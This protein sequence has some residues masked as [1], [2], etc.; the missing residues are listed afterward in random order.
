M[1]INKGLILL[2]MAGIALVDI[3]FYWNSHLY[4]RAKEKIIASE[5]K[6]RVLEKANI[7]YTFHDPV[8]YELG[9]AYSDLGISH[10]GDASLRDRYFRKSYEYFYKALRMNP[11]FVFAHFDFAQSLLFMNSLSLP[12]IAPHINYFE[13]YKKAALLTGHN[14][15]IYYEVGK[16][17]FAQWPSLTEEEK[18]FTLMMLTKIMEQKNQ[19][20]LMALLQIWDMNV[21][22][23]GTLGK[24]LPDDSDVFRLYARFLG[25][26]SLSLEERQKKLAH[27][28]F[29]ELQKAKN[30]LSLGER[31]YRFFR[32]KEASS[33]YSTCLS[34]LDKINF[35]QTL[36]G[37]NLIDPQEYIRIRKAGLLGLVKSRLDESGLLKEAKK[38][39]LFYISLETGMKALADL[40]SFL[41]ERGMIEK[42]LGF[43]HKDMEKFAFEVILNFKQNKFRDVIRAGSYMDQNLIVVPEAMKQ[44]YVRVLHVIGD[45]YQKLDYLYESNNYFQ[46]ALDIESGNLEVLTGL[47][48][49]YARLNN[50]EKMKETES[51]IIQILTPGEIVLSDVLISK[52]QEFS[53]SL[54]LDG[55]NARFL[56]SWK[57]DKR[58][59]L[60]L[61]TVV[62]NNRVIWEDYLQEENLSLEVPTEIGENGLKVIPV[63]KPISLSRISYTLS[64]PL[65]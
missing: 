48:K 10:L 56:L 7:F 20:K 19:E 38:E 24:I 36:L 54:V 44:D 14:M 4:S 60:P 1:K 2:A 12:F 21:R 5:E 16:I 64:A 29:L 3:C 22:D 58:G 47:R 40:E 37:N 51:K 65:Q 11:A 61:V 28:E 53:R 42:N 31:E 6:I 17:L 62:F 23:Y 25:E 18:D 13:E 26:K 35:Y 33:H 50:E 46:K 27:A 55:R 43:S 30:D 49:N 52:G 39:L 45:S 57:L 15:Q 41:V 32:L 34:R 9:K 59:A 8:Y 63:N